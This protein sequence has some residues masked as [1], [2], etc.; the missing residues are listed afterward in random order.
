M[1]TVVLF[2]RLG[3][4]VVFALAG[5]AKLGDLAGS[6]RAVRAFGVP[7]A[8][9]GVV[10]TLLPLAE[11]AVAGCLI[12]S[13]SARW[14]AFGALILLG[15]FVVAIAAA[16]RRGSQPDCHCFGQL[17]SAPAGWPALA[18]NLV[19]AGV[20]AVVVLAGPGLSVGG[21]LGS[22]S[23]QRIWVLAGSLAAV[24]VAGQA[25]LI[26]RLLRRHGAVLIRLRELEAGAASGAATLAIGD[27]AP[28][29]DL[30]GLAGE[31]VSLA[32]LLSAGRDVLLVFTDP[33]C[34]PCQALLPQLAAWQDAHP[35]G[36]TVALI[37][38]GPAAASRSAREE[39]GLRHIARQADRET[40]IRYGVLGT[41]SAIL[42]GADGRVR[43]PLAAGADQIARLA[44]SVQAAT[45]PAS[46]RDGERDGAERAI[47]V[48]PPDANGASAPG[49]AE[50]RSATG[51]ATGVAA[52]SGAAA[53][54][55]AAGGERA[56]ANKIAGE[57]GDLIRKIAPETFAASQALRAARITTPGKPNRVPA[58]TQAAW[59]RRLH[60]IDQVHASIARVHGA[61]AGRTAALDA[62]G[63]LRAACRAG[64]LALT[65][66]TAGKRNNYAKQ[67]QADERR[68]HTAIQTLTARLH[69]AG[70]T[71]L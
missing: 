15:G 36:L 53:A 37:S 41:P 43:G 29:F 7:V 68:L 49:R 39:H 17:H 23:H 5:A 46:A 61:D 26:W 48:R 1:S 18:R 11:L 9:A 16:L 20:A 13:R 42:V 30:P 8:L 57:L 64:E 47:E 38:R 67:Q 59:Q 19:F 21:W 2:A 55:A 24:V 27:P 58:A 50:R 71:K 35:E 14:G 44:Q 34:G 60:D 31:R 51:L 33:H 28:P 32:G 66:P 40:D 63:L 4:A 69:Q 54:S 25:G 45:L 6:R 62:L 10:G 12:G 70:A 65:S 3:L 22:L 56:A 52:L